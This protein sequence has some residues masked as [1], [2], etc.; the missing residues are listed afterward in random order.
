VR[1]AVINKKTS[2]IIPSVFQTWLLVWLV[3]VWGFTSEME[4][5]WTM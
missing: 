2:V 3:H 5:D 1:D 4:L